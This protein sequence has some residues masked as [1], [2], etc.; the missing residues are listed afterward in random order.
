[1]KI[2]PHE[3]IQ[4]L[5]GPIMLEDLVEKA[6]RHSEF[7]RGKIYRHLRKREQWITWNGHKVRHSECLLCFSAA[8]RWLAI[9]ITVR[10]IR[11]LAAY[12]IDLGCWVHIRCCTSDLGVDSKG[13][14]ITN[15]LQNKVL[16]SVDEE[17][18][19]KGSTDRYAIVAPR[20]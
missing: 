10:I 16:V 4:M 13:R 14:L 6:V 9:R 15:Y 17:I 12:V 11:N 8:P 19:L 3:Y 5:C 2:P 1:M 20:A 7:S 18:S